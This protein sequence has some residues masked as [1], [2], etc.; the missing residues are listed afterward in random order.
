MP[1]FDAIAVGGGLAGAA[2]ALEQ[3]RAGA[4]VAVIERTAKPTLKVCGDFL[5]TEAQE[6][7]SHLGL[8]VGGMGA[9]RI[10]NLRLVTGERTAS[11]ELP[12]AAAGLSRLALDEALLAKAAAAGAEVIRGE[13]ITAL[14]PHGRAVRIRTGTRM[15]TAR[16][17]ALATGKHNMRGWSRRQG[18]ITAYK[19]SLAPSE[20]AA[21]ALA[22]I[23][24]LVSYRGGYIGACIIED[25]KASICW[26][27]DPAA[28]R[29]V[30]AD[31]TAQLDHLARQSSAVGD[32]LSG[33][34]FLSARPAAV[35]AIPYGYTRKEAIAPNV[36]AI[37]DQLCVI[38][39]FTGDGTSLALSSGLAAAHA[40]LQ[41]APAHEFQ[42]AFLARTQTQMLW[43]RAVDASLKWAPTRRLGVAATAAI[44]SL[45]RLAASLTRIRGIDAMRVPR[46][47]SAWARVSL[48]LRLQ[49]LHIGGCQPFPADAPVAA[50]NL[51]HAH[52]SYAAH[53]FALDLD[54]GI[55]D[56]ADHGFLLALV[57]DAFD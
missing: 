39:S 12:F 38:P 2:F 35:S 4:R 20:P 27:M 37:G 49:G 55:R 10:T 44:P 43:A 45:A 31:W 47:V 34:Q 54:H 46:R 7:L 53:G 52:P 51:V 14:E 24:Q 29:T 41:G 16:C 3:A 6:L 17:A 32:M 5:S 23:V 42:S 36:Y 18:A 40:V 11:V 50:R 21:R 48:A 1:D 9:A 15:L 13:A 19:I 33:A 28:M 25:S 26:M 57:E 8:D 22:G 30:G 56:L